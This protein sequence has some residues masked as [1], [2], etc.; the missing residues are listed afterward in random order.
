MAAMSRANGVVAHS[1]PR[2]AK[3]LRPPIWVT[4]RSACSQWVRTWKAPVKMPAQPSPISSRPTVNS[5]AEPA[6][7]NSAVPAAEKSSMAVSVRRG[8]K[9]SS[10]IPVGTCMTA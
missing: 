3:L 6:V 4:T 9:R 2:A 7:A 8:P 1:V 5:V 10:S